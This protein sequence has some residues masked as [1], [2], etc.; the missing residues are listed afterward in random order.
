MSLVVSLRVPDGIVAAA[1]SVSLAQTILEFVAQDLRCPSCK[2]KI[3]AQD[4]GI[5]AIPVP[6]S[7]SS[8]TQKLFSLYDDFSLSS[9]GQG[10]INNRSIYYH[11]KQFE[12]ANRKLA[13]LVEARDAFISYLEQEL[14]HQ[15]PKYKEEAPENWYPLGFHLNGYEAVDGTQ[16]GVTYEVHIGRQNIIH[17]YDTIGCTVGGDIKV[18]QQLWAIGK[19]DPRLQFKYGLFSLQDAI[20]LSEFLIEATSSFQRFANQVPTVGGETDVALI[21]PFRGFQWIKRKKLMET[22]EKSN[23]NR[24]SY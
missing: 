9:F 19:E 20:D 16:V 5:P 12:R 22:L 14:L 21:T 17:R 13:N 24:N 18:V 6:F 2:E 23:E 11:V 3:S 10:I 4:I 15:L 1:D 7:A 8:Y